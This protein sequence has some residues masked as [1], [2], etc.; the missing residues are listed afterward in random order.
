MAFRFLLT[1]HTPL[2]GFLD[3]RLRGNDNQLKFGNFDVKI[4][5]KPFRDKAAVTF[6]ARFFPA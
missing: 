6:F 2:G 3:S 5:F 4:L 1:L